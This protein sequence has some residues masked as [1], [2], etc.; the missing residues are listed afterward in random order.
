M[1]VAKHFKPLI[2]SSNRRR[3]KDNPFF[4]L[5]TR[6]NRIP[7]LVDY[8]SIGK[9]SK[10]KGKNVKAEGWREKAPFKA[11]PISIKQSRVVFN[12]HKLLHN[13][14]HNPILSWNCDLKSWFWTWKSQFQ[15]KKW[16]C[17]TVFKALI[18]E[19]Y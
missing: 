2:T 6:K 16:V 18:H 3:N 14:T 1:L 5:K 11:S 19:V 4:R 7:I 8:W 9:S 10:I 13:F 17:K 12:T 15:L